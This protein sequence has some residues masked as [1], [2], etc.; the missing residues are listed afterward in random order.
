MKKHTNE[1]KRIL[2][3]LNLWCLCF[4]NSISHI[5][6]NSSPKFQF[7]NSPISKWKCVKL[8]GIWQNKKE[9]LWISFTIFEIKSQITFALTIEKSS[10]TGLTMDSHSQHSLWFRTMF[11]RQIEKEA[12]QHNHKIT[13][14]NHWV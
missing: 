13:F 7:A 10:L 5:H 8:H 2:Y 9:L 11:L 6:S 14:R 1:E 12:T 4:L 3:L